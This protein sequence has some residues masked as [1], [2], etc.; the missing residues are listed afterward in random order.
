LGSTFFIGL[1][2]GLLFIPNL[3]DRYGRK[4]ILVFSAILAAVFHAILII[5]H[6]FELTLFAS[7]VMGLT[8]S[9][10]NIVG[11]NYIKELLMEDLQDK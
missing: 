1:F 2:V 4:S 11:L 5:S 7:A 10:K 9:A 8:W 6:S 3:S